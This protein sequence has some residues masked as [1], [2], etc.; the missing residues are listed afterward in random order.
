[1]VSKARKNI[2]NGINLNTIL[3]SL[4]RA[5]GENMLNAF[6]IVSAILFWL[7]KLLIVV[8]LIKEARKNGKYRRPK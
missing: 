2:C 8:W 1:M 4:F 3:M 7:E 5:M 6:I